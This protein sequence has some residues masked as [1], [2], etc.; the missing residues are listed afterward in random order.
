MANIDSPFGL[1]P[2]RHKSGASYN[3]AANP[4][5]IASTY[6][7]ALFVGDPVVKVAGG[8]NAA[9]VKAP[10]VG[11][12][13]IGTLPSVEKTV[14]GDVDGV[15]KMITG[16]IVGFAANPANLDQKHNPASTERIAFVADDPDLVFEIQADGA[17]PAASMGLNAVLIATHSGS[18]STGLSGI[19]LDT[20]SD[21]PAADAS[22][23][24]LI[25]RAVNRED[26]DTTLTH[27][28]VEVLINC[29]TQAPGSTAAG[30]GTLG[31]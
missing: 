7:T 21:V 19:E 10:G 5:Y 6:A 3:G 25:V 8:S 4:Y 28:K 23:Q 26:N 20:T 16:V 9:A 12:F 27:A 24:L 29:H 30:D 2:V 11:T 18:T 17:I 13:G 31:I 1:R 14:V 15:T 22:N